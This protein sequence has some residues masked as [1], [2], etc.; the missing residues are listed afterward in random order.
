LPGPFSYLNDNSEHPAPGCSVRVSYDEQAEECPGILD[1]GADYTSVPI[2]LIEILAVEQCGEL[3]VEGATGGPEWQG[4]YRVN[5]E[6]LGFTIAYHPVLGGT[7]P[8]ARDSIL[9]GRDILNRYRV[10]LAGP[11]LEFFID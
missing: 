5:L 10:L 4:V 8:A 9:I 11:D 1:S 7:G 3:E 2:D 6:F